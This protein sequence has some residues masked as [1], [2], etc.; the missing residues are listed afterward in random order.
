[1][2]RMILIVTLFLCSCGKP[3]N[4]KEENYQSKSELSIIEKFN[5]KLTKEYSLKGIWTLRS[6][7]PAPNVR[8]DIFTN[9]GKN[10]LKS[11]LTNAKG[12]YN[13]KILAS[14][15]KGQFLIRCTHKNAVKS[16]LVSM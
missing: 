2:D 7:K 9:D 16:K 10:F 11:T 4:N 15:S 12:H 13:T 6:G 5:F 14:T 1:M 8:L 3:Q